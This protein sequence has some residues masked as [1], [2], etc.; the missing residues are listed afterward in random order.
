M[1]DKLGPS[2]GPA[3]YKAMNGDVLA[4]IITMVEPNGECCLTI[5]PP[6][7]GPDFYSRIKF[8]RNAGPETAKP[9]TVYR[10]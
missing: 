7:R 9:G 5:F 3:L 4:C 10:W 2:L 6:M 1:T 8:D